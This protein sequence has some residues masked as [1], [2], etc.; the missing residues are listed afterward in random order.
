M[1]GTEF[2]HLMKRLATTR[3]A[4]LTAL[5]GLAAGSVAALIG[6]R[7]T[8]DEADA[9]HRQRKRTICHCSNSSAASCRTLTKAKKKVRKHLQRHPCDYKGRCK[10]FSGCAPAAQCQNNN[11]CSGGQ[12]CSNGQCVDCTGDAQCTGGQVCVNGRCQ[13]AAKCQNNNQCTAGQVCVGGQCVDCTSYTQCPG[14]TCRGGVCF[15]GG[16]CANS[17]QCVAPTTCEDPPATGSDRFCLYGNIC[18]TNADC[19]MFPTTPICVLGI[20]TSE[21]VAGGAACPAG[22]SCQAGVCQPT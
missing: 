9:H 3:L 16:P 17:T 2:D 14:Q 6:M 22:Q 1:D 11:Q 10:G 15:G 12:V 13:Q 20:C 8:A 5:R 19:G 4:R 7:L 18:S 21:C